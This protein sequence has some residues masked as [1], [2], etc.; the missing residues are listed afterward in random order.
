M[1]LFNN[2]NDGQ[3]NSKLNVKIDLTNVSVLAIPSAV[4]CR[5]VQL[6]F[7]WV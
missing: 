1:S 4:S 6:L 5:E 2:H 7:E 3:L